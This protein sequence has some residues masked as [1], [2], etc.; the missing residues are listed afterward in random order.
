MKTLLAAAALLFCSSVCAQSFTITA[1]PYPGWFL[2]DPDYLPQEI[3]IVTVAEYSELRELCAPVATSRSTAGGCAIREATVCRVY[4]GPFN[5]HE[6][7]CAL[8]HELKHCAGWNHVHDTHD[9]H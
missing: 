1:P 2:K 9:C 7:N 3:R 5:R 6:M 4:L 8:R